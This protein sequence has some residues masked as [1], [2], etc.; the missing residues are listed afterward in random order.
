[1]KCPACKR[2]LGSVS[3]EE[4]R[5]IW[6]WYRVLQKKRVERCEIR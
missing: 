5:I 4:E 3:V 6:E 1:M 2:D